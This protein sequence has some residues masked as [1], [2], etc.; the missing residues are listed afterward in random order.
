M[1]NTRPFPW[2]KIVIRIFNNL[3]VTSM[4]SCKNL[5]K[6][7]VHLYQLSSAIENNITLKKKHRVNHRFSFALF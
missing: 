2:I 4:K 1:I 3:H 6:A 7:L 5:F